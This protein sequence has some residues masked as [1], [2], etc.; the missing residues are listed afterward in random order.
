[1]KLNVIFEDNHLLVLQK[2]PNI[3][4]QADSS[5][6]KDLLNLAKEYIKTK[7]GKPGAVYLGLV[8]RLDRPVGG[9]IVFARTSKAAA[10]LSADMQKGLWGKQYLAIVQGRLPEKANLSDYLARD[11]KTRNA[12]IT[13]INNPNGKKADLRFERLSEEENG[14]SLLD[15]ELLTGRHH[16]IRVQLSSR[17]WPIWGDARYNPDSKAG[18]QIALWAYKLNILHPTKRE[19]MTFYALP[20]FSEKPW[21]SFADLKDSLSR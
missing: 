13:D 19:R 2:Q 14:L 6:D 18:Q 10:R 16:Q 4:V 5:G 1:M 9:L 17:N 20:P 15:I 21:E 11:E 3:P 12:Y 8:H 7:Y